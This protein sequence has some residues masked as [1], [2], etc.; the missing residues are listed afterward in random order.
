MAARDVNLVIRARDEASRAITGIGDTIEGLLSGATQASGGVAA[1][2]KALSTLD[3][4]YAT[5]NGKA[6]TAA[7]AFDRQSTALAANRAQLEA[8]TAQAG[9]AAR[10]IETLRGRVVDEALAGRDTSPIIAQIKA[11]EAEQGRLASQAGKLQ[12]T[13]ADQESAVDRSR[14]SLLQLGSTV[15]AVRDA[16]AEAAAR[17]E[18]TTQALTAQAAAS[19][20]VTD[21]QRR[22][23][24]LTGVDRPDASGSAQ[25][26]ASILIEA[27]NIFRR[28]EARQAELRVLREQEAAIAALADAEQ[29]ER[30]NRRTFGISDDPRGDRARESASVFIEAANAEDRMAREAAELRAQLDPAAA[31]QERLNA[32]VARFRE[33]AAAGKISAEELAIAEARVTAEAGRRPHGNA[34]G[35]FGLKPYELQN[36]SYQ[37]NDVVTQLASG[38]SLTQTLGQQGGQILQIF[39]R[40][41]SALI[42]AFSNPFFLGAAAVAGTI[43]AGIKKAADEAERLRTF[44]G[45]LALRADGGSYNSAQLV[46]EVDALQRLGASAKEAEGAVNAFLAGSLDPGAFNAFGRAARDTAHILGSDLPTAAKDVAGA[47]TG[48]YDAIATFDDKLKFLT[49]TQREHIRTLFDDGEAERART[50]A[51]GI[52]IGRADEAAAKQRGSWASAT[53]HLA[54]AWHN[55]SA[56]IG[57]TA[58]I[59]AIIAKFNELANLIDRIAN[60]TDGR[61]TAQDVDAELADA[62]EHLTRLQD[63]VSGKSSLF[64]RPMIGGEALADAQRDIAETGRLIARLTAERAA[65]AAVQNRTPARVTN[66]DP[67]GTQAKDRADQ[68][69]HISSE[70]NLQR[71]RDAGQSRLLSARERARREEMAGE[72]AARGVADA[73]V[74]A[75]ERRRAV[76][77]ETAAIEREADARNRANRAER[78]RS[79]KDYLSAIVG[80]EGGAGRNRAGSSATGAGQFT[81]GTFVSLY[82]QVNP[83]TQLS[84]DRIADQRRDQKVALQLLEVFTRANARLLEKA[85]KAV[86]GA[87][88]Y[89]L[90]FLG[91]G[92]GLAALRA[93]GGTP[94]DQVIRRSDPRNAD[95]I[96]RQNGPYLF[97]GR[98]ADR[99]PR[100]VAELQTFLGGRVGESGRAQ[101]SLI[102]NEASLIEDA[103]QQQEAFN[104]AVRH[105]AEDRHRAVDGLRA[106]AGLRGAALLAE[107]RRQAVAQAELDL[108]QRAEDANK[109][110]KPGEAPVAVSP[111]QVAQAKALAAAYFD[112]QHA[113]EAMNVALAD[114]ERPVDNLSAQR[115]LLREQADFL[116]GIGDNEG[117]DKLDRQVTAINAKIQA[118]VEALITFYRSLS[119]EQLVEL[120]IHSNDELDNLIAKLRIG[121]ETSQEW[122]KV[123][124]IPANEIARAFSGQL[125]NSITNFLNKVGAGQNVFRALAESVREFA[126][127]FIS[128]IA[129]MILQLLAYAA[130]VSILRALGVPVPSGAS[131]FDAPTKHTGGI[132]GQADGN[133][134]RSVSPAIWSAAIR[135]HNG[136]IAGLKPNEVPTILER[137][138]EVLTRG[139]ARH[140]ANGGGAGGSTFEQLKIVNTFDADDAAEQMLRTRAGEKAILNYMR[141]NSRAVKAALG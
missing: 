135:Y 141:V 42:G 72:L 63:S 9:A 95:T 4:A 126:A 91:S 23:N 67:N 36:L 96:F 116:R 129:Q 21:L 97:T 123:A 132:A 18:L 120:G 28:A 50:E 112:A 65:L 138:E 103:R 136:G 55:L 140:R 64:G 66:D 38:T 61:R 106:E 117:A 92:T 122:G 40:A 74:A 102:E 75:A 105:G 31:A 49:A 77:K 48:G 37:V 134:R 60:L 93:P 59:V 83:D 16:Q 2:G 111:E 78:E 109:S 5:I 81:R 32:T 52:Y 47:F 11:V 56:V 29:A 22:I 85:G 13:I 139:D 1:L 100:T 118:A 30:A 114:R 121:I 73:A 108:R 33:L 20:R 128:S 17:I 84:D 54:G 7:A 94:I 27:D 41:A 25:A 34:P 46:R 6:D 19:E 43:A 35:L 137:G 51:F 69:A 39:P 10:S 113:A 82:R 71:L 110:L 89:L 133:A 98:G 107:Q 115:E 119:P 70:E 24:S 101:S 99:R 14:S 45:A 3:K 15:H 53:E 62:R 130:A 86:N 90:H 57:D 26:A 88:L 104:T 79:I 124:G 12:R 68:L 127:Q 8:V 131:I 80:A 44:N 58:P 76:A 87:N 125:V